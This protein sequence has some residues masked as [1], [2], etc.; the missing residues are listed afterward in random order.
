MRKLLCGPRPVAG[1]VTIGLTWLV[2]LGVGANGAAQPQLPL[3]PRPL[4]LDAYMPVPPDNPLAAATVALGAS[5]FSDRRLSGDGSLSCRDCHDPDRAFTDGRP[6]SVGILGR[7]GPRNV[8]TLINR[9]YGRA[10]FWDGRSSTLEDQVLGPIT[11]PL[12]LGA[13]IDETVARL[14]ADS[15]ARLAFQAAFGREPNGADLARALAAYVRTIVGGNSAVDRFL[16]GDRDALSTEAR[17]GLLLF[18]GR[19]NCTACHLGP[20]FSDERFHNTGVAWRDGWLDDGRFGVTRDAR[21]RGAFKTPT[22]RE[23]AR[24]APYMHDGSLASLEDVVEFYARGGNANP[25]L[26]PEVRP[27][28]LDAADKRALVAF[29]RALTGTIETGVALSSRMA[30]VQ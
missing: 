9:G 7:R 16:H 15:A 18:R 12:E 4:G 30:G 8:P 19:G 6:T 2:A 21:D 27:L 3:L 25:A 14:R 28:T 20:T 13:T 5:L 22:L 10:Q 17:D 29:L 23:V 26:D 24:T 1:L 11:N